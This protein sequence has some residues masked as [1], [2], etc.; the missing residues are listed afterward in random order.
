MGHLRRLLKVSIPSAAVALLVGLLAQ[1]VLA[2][3]KPTY[4]ATVTAQ[5]D[6]QIPVVSGDAYLYQMTAPYLALA[7]SQTVRQATAH[8]M[9][10]GWDADR[11]GENAVVK[12]S[13]SPLLLD[14][15]GTAPDRQQA[16]MLATLTVQSLDKESRAQRLQEL[17]RAVAVP[18]AELESL[19]QQVAAIDEAFTEKYGY[20]DPTADGD[21]VRANL[22]LRIQDLVNQINRIREGGVNGL[23]VLAAPDAGSIAATAPVSKSV[24]LFAALL[25]FIVTAEALAFTRGRFGRRLTMPSAERITSAN[26]MTIETRESTSTGFPPVTAGLIARRASRDQRTMVIVTIRA[27]STLRTWLA[28]EVHPE[29]IEVELMTSNWAAKLGDQIGLVIVMACV[30]ENARR[31][32]AQTAKTLSSLGIPSRMVLIPVPGASA[33]TDTATEA[34]ANDSAAEPV[35]ASRES[36]DVDVDS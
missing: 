16:L 8:E 4:T 28:G 7:Q 11:V 20:S 22:V 27:E 33:T 9:G 25:A 14:V 10:I 3:I 35:T 24:A 1:F 15:T 32:V 26:S 18:S 6:A 34:L 17:D 29:L 36:N 23:S 30:G 19:Q 5:I 31:A 13:K 21:P 2:Q 12:V